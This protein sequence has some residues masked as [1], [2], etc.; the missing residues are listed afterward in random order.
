MNNGMSSA[1][2]DWIQMVA[3]VLDRV[4]TPYYDGKAIRVTYKVFLKNSWHL[5]DITDFKKWIY[6]ILKMCLIGVDAGLQTD[7]G[8][9]CRLTHA[10]CAVSNGA[11]S[12]PLLWQEARRNTFQ[13]VI[14]ILL[15]YWCWQEKCL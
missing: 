12:L 4:K 8:P 13:V 1:L 15:L 10:M 3:R 6:T 7:S 11:V 14:F 5:T 9:H 2:S